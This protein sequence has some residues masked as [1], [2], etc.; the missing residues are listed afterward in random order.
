MPVTIAR[1]S[2]IYGPG[3]RRLLK[4][5]R[6]VARRRF[7]VLG[8]GNI[9][10]HLTYIDD[11]VEG[12]RL[13]GEVPAAANRTYILAGGEVTTLNELMALI[14]AEAGVAAAGVEAARLAVL[15]G[16]RRVR[17][18]LRAA[19]HRAADISPA[20]G[21]LHQEPRV[22]HQPGARRDRLRPA[23]RPA[24][25]HPTNAGVVQRA[26]VAVN[27]RF[28]ASRMSCL[29]PGVSARDKY[30]ALIVGKPGW[31][32]LV[33]YELVVLLSQC[34]P[35]ALGLALRKSAVS[36]AAGRLRTQRRL[37]PERRASASSQ[38][39]HRRQRRHRR[40]LPASMPKASRT[41]A[42]GSAAASSSGETRFCRARTATS[43][44]ARARTSDSTAKS[45]PRAA[46]ASAATR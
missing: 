41:P 24:R 31:D 13:C 8:S 27:P 32:A 25:R 30:S 16:R 29:E 21:L 19:R 36:A 6:G 43:S 35:G 11:L 38:D 17:S 5:F 23:G 15:A 20:R 10:Y 33:K 7:V 9:F 34:V 44:W 45:F 4:L 26:R 42:S 22:R 3:D 46:C 40:Q 18:R 1:P 12:F 28:R 2:G 14:A 39:P 37:R